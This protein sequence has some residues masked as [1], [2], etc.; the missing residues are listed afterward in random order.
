MASFST[1]EAFC[2]YEELCRIIPLLT[3]DSTTPVTANEINPLIEQFLIKCRASIQAIG[4]HSALLLTPEDIIAKI[5]FK[6]GD[7][8]LEIE[9]EVFGLLEQNPYPHI[10]RW[11]ISR[12]DIVF[13]PFVGKRT[14]HDRI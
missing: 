11:Y 13:M 14:L 12:P 7:P 4:G 9:Q 1:A 6:S 3:A 2:S 10:V 5:S 8:R